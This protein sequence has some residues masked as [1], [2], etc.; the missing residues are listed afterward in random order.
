MWNNNSNNNNKKYCAVKEQDIDAKITNLFIND[1]L[2]MID[3]EPTNY[4]NRRK[5][6]SITPRWRDAQN[7]KIGKEKRIL[8][9]FYH[10]V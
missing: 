6:K 8:H 1:L 4:N 7:Q 10:L 3:L 2:Q 9:T 5:T